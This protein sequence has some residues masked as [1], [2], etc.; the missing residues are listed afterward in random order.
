MVPLF[1][2]GV[3]GCQEEFPD[4]DPID[5]DGDGVLTGI[6]DGD[7]EGADVTGGP[8]L[9]GC[10]EKEAEGVVGVKFECKAEYE[11]AVNGEVHPAVGSD[12]PLGPLGGTVLTVN[13]STYDD[14]IA[15]ACCSEVEDFPSDSCELATHHRACFIDLLGH[16]CLS[17]ARLVQARASGIVLLNGH[18]AV[19][20]AGDDL[21]DRV[22]EC[23]DHFWRGGD[24]EC[25]PGD[26]CQA[27]LCEFAHDSFEDLPTWN[28]GNG[29][30]VGG[31][32][33]VDI[34]VDLHVVVPDDAVQPPP[35]PPAACYS[36]EENDGVPPPVAP[37]GSVGSF[38]SPTADVP[39]DVEG[40]SWEGSAIV[41]EGELSSASEIH[42]YFDSSGKLV[43]DEWSLVD[44]GP[45]IVGTHT[46]QSDVESF[47]L[48]L[49]G[50]R[51]L[52]IV[53]GGWQIAA[54]KASFYL[55]AT[56]DGRGHAVVAT[57]AT[58]LRFVQVGG[59]SGGCPTFV[60][61]CLVSRPFTIAYDDALGGHWELDIPA[62]TWVP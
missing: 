49:S 41:G 11:L 36:S 20:E 33:V 44:A 38:L 58:T 1:A 48:L 52:P 31:S 59:G 23:L 22:N 45:T 7:D 37:P 28:A 30:S 13:D 19:Q 8:E 5:T 56:I 47:Y 21:R 6:V 2:Y 26:L 39:I 25:D 4:V 57:N 14:P 43:V 3:G 53:S 29:P 9:V 46:V 60:T 18:S 62:T 34:T 35:D 51:T 55:G 16:V 50:P 12:Y 40:P 17:S 32:Q 42:R 54:D 10:L 27:D 61:S 24:E 15:M